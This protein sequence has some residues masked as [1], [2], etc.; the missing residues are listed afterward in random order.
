MLCLG[1]FYRDFGDGVGGGEL[2]LGCGVMIRALYCI[3]F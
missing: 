3:V 2:I 1:F